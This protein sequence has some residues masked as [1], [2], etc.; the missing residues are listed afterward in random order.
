[1]TD[2]S[3]GRAADSTYALCKRVNGFEDSLRL[4]IQKQVVVTKVGAGKVPVKVLRLRIKCKSICNQWVDRFYDPLYFLRRKICRRR[5]L[6][7]RGISFAADT[8]KATLLF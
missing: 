5:Q 8:F 4:F 7:G 1:M 6:F 3:N 2:T